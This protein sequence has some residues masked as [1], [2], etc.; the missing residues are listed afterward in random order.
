MKLFKVIL[1]LMTVFGVLLSL[2]TV[3]Y[4]SRSNCSSLIRIPIDIKAINCALVQFE[5]RNGSL[6]VDLVE[7]EESGMISLSKDPWG[8]DYQ[9][10]PNASLNRRVFSLGAD[11]EVGG[12]GFAADIYIDTD[13]NKL[14]AQY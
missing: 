3:S 4:C 5:A 12:E 2:P 1:I 8:S 10:V 11:G 14:I 13:I 6:P 7:I 9:Y